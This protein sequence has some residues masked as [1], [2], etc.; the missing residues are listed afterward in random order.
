MNKHYFFI[1]TLLLVLLPK[2]IVGQACPFPDAALTLEITAIDDSAIYF[3]IIVTNEG[4]A[5]LP[6]SQMY[7]QSYVSNDMVDLEPAGGAVFNPN[8]AALS[9][10][11]RDTIS[12]SVTPSSIDVTDFKYLTIEIAPISPDNW[13]ECDMDN[14]TT[15]VDIPC[16]D[17]FTYGLTI[18]QVLEDRID[19]TVEIDNEGNR[20]LKLSRFIRQNYIGA[21]G[22]SIPQGIPAGGSIFNNTQADV[23]PGATYTMEYS[24]Y[25]NTNEVDIDT[26]DVLMVHIKPRYADEEFEC[27]NDNNVA[28]G[29]IWE[30][31]NISNRNNNNA[32]IVKTKSDHIAVKGF[33][34]T[35]SYRVI[36]MN[37]KVIRQGSQDAHTIPF[38]GVGGLYM[39]QLA[40]DS[41]QHN[42]LIHIP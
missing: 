16:Q 9:P 3:S 11:E 10:G 26:M 28:I 25:I 17:A 39:L 40:G 21:F 31:T 20:P 18:I 7:W 38:H 19:Y 13:E 33:K 8:Q 42:Q 24:A 35:F 2:K 22:D 5:D 36:T 29:A 30:P 41:T 12:R 37:G 27:R 15:H 4:N 34:G 1:G 23:E 32:I 14:N 6:L